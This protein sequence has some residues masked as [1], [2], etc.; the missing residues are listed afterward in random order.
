MLELSSLLRNEAGYTSSITSTNVIA[1]GCSRSWWPH[2]SPDI[3]PEGEIINRPEKEACPIRPVCSRSK[4]GCLN[5]EQW[6]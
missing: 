5:P 4:V 3:L 1:A 2:A 6:A